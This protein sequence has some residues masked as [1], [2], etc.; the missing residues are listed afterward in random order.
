MNM[1]LPDDPPELEPL[2]QAAR[3]RQ[4]RRPR[5]DACGPVSFMCWI[6]AIGLD[7]ERGSQ[8]APRGA[9]SRRPH[10]FRGSGRGLDGP[11]IIK[12]QLTKVA[13]FVLGWPGWSSGSGLGSLE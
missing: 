1:S 7:R 12:P 8:P 10:A 5:A 3:R 9:R 4:T 11:S 6:R 2:L 13:T